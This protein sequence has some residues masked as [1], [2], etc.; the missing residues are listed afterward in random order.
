[1]A[2]YR[3]RD[4]KKKKHVCPWFLDSRSY[5]L[6][7]DMPPMFCPVHCTRMILR[8]EP[9]FFAFHS[10]HSLSLS[11]VASVRSFFLFGRHPYSHTS[12][13]AKDLMKKQML[14][15][16]VCGS[17]SSTCSS[18]DLVFFFYVTTLKTKTKENAVGVCCWYSLIASIKHTCP[19]GWK[20]K[21]FF[22]FSFVL[23]FFLIAALCESSWAH[24]W[25][26]APTNLYSGVG[27]IDFRLIDEHT[28]VGY[29]THVWYT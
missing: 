17:S 9:L 2:G 19:A 24:D 5:G 27:T 16:W 8:R 26:L 23:Q 7:H 6:I 1:M 10:G 3:E 20:N 4:R 29:T 13:D 15:T 18:S 25:W 14:H 21:I 28:G 11:L 12:I 22:F